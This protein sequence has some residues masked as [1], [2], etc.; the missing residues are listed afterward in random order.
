MPHPPSSAHVLK[1]ERSR[2]FEFSFA[3]MTKLTCL[4]PHRVVASGGAVV[5]GPPFEIGAPH[6]TFGPQ[7]AADIQSCILE[8]W[9][10]FWF[11]APLLLNPGDGPATTDSS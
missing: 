7:V 6:F 4:L 2:C 5:P 1:K 10:P 11:L 8:V 3:D 9:P